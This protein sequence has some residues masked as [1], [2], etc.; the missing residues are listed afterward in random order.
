[1]KSLKIGDRF[2]ILVLDE[3]SK[4]EIEFCGKVESGKNVMGVIRLVVN[5]KDL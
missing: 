5:V 4:G 1:M 2:S 3:S